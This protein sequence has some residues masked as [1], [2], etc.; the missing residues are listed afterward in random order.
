[1]AAILFE[2]V[3]SGGGDT[4]SSKSTPKK[5]QIKKIHK[6]QRE[7]RV[8]NIACFFEVGSLHARAQPITNRRF[9][10]GVHLN[11]SSSCP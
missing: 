3:W 4:R 1:M 10:S 8:H 6:T 9:V 5:K 7:Q 2:D 11:L